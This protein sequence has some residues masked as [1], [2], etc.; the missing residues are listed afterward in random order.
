MFTKLAFC[1]SFQY[2]NNYGYKKFD[3]SVANVFF[4]SH[5]FQ[6]FVFLQWISFS[7]ISRLIYS[8]AVYIMKKAKGCSLLPIACSTLPFSCLSN[9][10]GKPLPLWLNIALPSLWDIKWNL[11]R[12]YYMFNIPLEWNISTEVQW[13]SQ[14]YKLFM[15]FDRDRIYCSFNILKLLI[16]VDI[17]PCLC[18]SL[19]ALFVACFSFVIIGVLLFHHFK[20]GLLF[21]YVILVT[22]NSSFLC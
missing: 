3:N 15:L 17:V 16:C 14:V 12:L 5:R 11:S 21:T 9:S 10:V 6:I 4:I 7:L 13:P 19:I 1:K 18:R 22:A 2:I 8:R 20:V